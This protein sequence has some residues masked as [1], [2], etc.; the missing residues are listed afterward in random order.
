ME[1]ESKVL[2]QE[3]WTW[4]TWLAQPVK[5]LTLAHVMISRFVGSSPASSSVLTARSLEPVSDSVSP[6]L[7]ASPTRALIPSV[8]KINKHLKKKKKDGQKMIRTEDLGFWLADGVQPNRA[9]Y[10]S[11]GLCR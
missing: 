10:S 1:L 7:S 9:S 2:C 5:R 11:L 8:S 6:S 4:G 3:G